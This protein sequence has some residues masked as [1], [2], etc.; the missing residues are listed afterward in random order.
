MQSAEGA[1]ERGEGVGEQGKWIALCAP[2]TVHSALSPAHQLAR[3][4]VFAAAFSRWPWFAL[5]LHAFWRALPSAHFLHSRKSTR[6][7]MSVSLPPPQP[8]PVRLSGPLPPLPL[9]S[10]LKVHR[11]HG[12]TV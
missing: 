8:A 12:G 3:A 10:G 9:R 4:S 1:R 6:T 2:T 7:S 11:P 5:C